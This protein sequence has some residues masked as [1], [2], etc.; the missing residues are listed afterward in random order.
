MMSSTDPA[1][2]RGPHTTTGLA[3]LATCPECGG[4]EFV[5]EELEDLVVFRCAACDLGWHYEL[6]Y[7][8]SCGSR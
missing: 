2:A 6:G 7:V 8:W 1:P 5:I 3:P 4:D